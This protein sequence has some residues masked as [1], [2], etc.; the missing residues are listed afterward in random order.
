MF[1][2]R[3]LCAILLCLAGAGPVC[4]QTP[5]TPENVFHQYRAAYFALPNGS[6]TLS[7]INN[8]DVV[9][10]TYF[11]G[12]STQ[13]AEAYLRYPDGRIEIVFIPNAQYLSIIKLTDNGEL[14][15]E[16]ED[17]RSGA[18]TGF[19][20]SAEGKIQTF[21]LGGA[22]GSTEP[23]GLN[24][25]GQVI[26]FLS[27]SN[28]IPP[29]QPFLRYRD[30]QYITFQV[31]N[32]DEVFTENINQGG[33]ALGSYTCSVDEGSVCGFYGKP[34]GT[35]TTFSYP[36]N[37]LIPAQINDAD[38]I[39]GVAYLAS[40]IDGFIR[41]RDGKFTL[42]GLTTVDPTNVKINNRNEVITDYVVTIPRGPGGDGG[43][44]DYD[45]IRTPDGKI[46]IYDPPYKPGSLRGI[47]INDRGV[48]AGQGGPQGFFLLTPKN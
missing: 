29:D 14:L 33:V 34:G 41:T 21:Q 5:A 27:T 12:T 13:T 23:T 31:K 6:S 20:R 43:R 30:G 42:F 48:I 46:G 9:A 17:V 2:S 37:G 32:S 15:G 36:P 11:P 47:A 44:Y 39:T 4:G 19:V 1:S 25:S 8:L 24:I 10:G 26:G 22:A 45:I 7:T 3:A 40:G 35:L 16:Y 18:D 28:T 38:V